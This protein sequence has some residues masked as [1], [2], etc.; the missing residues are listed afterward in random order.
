MIL[1]FVIQV[2]I[3]MHTAEVDPTCYQVSTIEKL[4]RDH[5]EQDQNELFC[6]VNAQHP[7][8]GMAILE[9]DVCQNLE[10]RDLMSSVEVHFAGAAT[11][12]CQSSGGQILDS[13]TVLPN[14][15]HREEDDS[16]PS[17][18]NDADVAIKTVNP[19]DGAASEEIV[20][21]TKESNIRAEKSNFP[22]SILL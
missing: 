7:E 4:K 5:F 3:L 1:G 14:Y 9:S 10:D 21:L 17:K 16:L 12:Q 18:T 15:G 13:D 19:K 11:E 6:K 8:T 22:S 2:N 20:S